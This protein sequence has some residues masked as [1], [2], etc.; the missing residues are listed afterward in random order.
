MLVKTASLHR[1]SAK[2]AA[3]LLFKVLRT[4]SRAYLKHHLQRQ[5]QQ[6]QQEQQ[7]AAAIIIFTF[8]CT[9]E[10]FPPRQCCFL[11]GVF[12]YSHIQ[13][14][15]KPLSNYTLGT[16]DHTCLQM[17]MGLNAYKFKA[18]R[19]T[20]ARL[21]KSAKSALWRRFLNRFY[22][23]IH[24]FLSIFEGASPTSTKLAVWRGLGQPF[25]S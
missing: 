1:R 4:T 22:I 13:S 23:R 16:F 25:G 3:G 9:P 20:D 8:V 6:R 5:K 11:R 14:A 19:H 15:R 24:Q 7:Q 2:G 18:H 12:S 10:A 17:P 21:T